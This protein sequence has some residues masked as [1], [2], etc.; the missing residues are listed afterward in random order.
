MITIVL[1]FYFDFV[2]PDVFPVCCVWIFILYW[3][4]FPSHIYFQFYCT[5]FCFLFRVF[6]SSLL[7][8]IFCFF[9]IFFLHNWIL[10]IPFSKFRSWFC[11]YGRL[12]QDQ[13]KCLNIPYSYCAESY[14]CSSCLLYNRFFEGFWTTAR[15]KSIL[16]RLRQALLI[17]LFQIPTAQIP[18]R[19]LLAGI[20]DIGH[21]PNVTHSGQFY[22]SWGFLTFWGR[23]F[24]CF[25]LLSTRGSSATM[26]S[27]NAVCNG[28]S[29]SSLSIFLFKNNFLKIS[30]FWNF[31]LW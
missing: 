16:Y 4:E 25:T 15:R 3:Q 13:A 20:P 8:S 30:K 24:D 31:V 28:R 29:I 9:I 12:I 2:V 14:P 17:P 26:G 19:V 21:H 18:V 11:T 23:F 5:V 22:F 7:I 27:L 6:I 1:L 10:C